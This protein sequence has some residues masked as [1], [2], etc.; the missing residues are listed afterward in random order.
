M[1]TWLMA[2]GRATGYAQ[3]AGTTKYLV[4]AGDLAIPVAGPH[5]SPVYAW[6]PYTWASLSL[7]VIRNFTTAPSTV[8]SWKNGSPGNQA[9]LIGPGQVGL[10]QDLM[11][12]DL[13]AE[14][15]FF[16]WKVV[17]GGGGVL[18][19][20]IIACILS[21]DSPIPMLICGNEI[22]QQSYGHNRFAAIAGMPDAT[23]K[24]DRAKYTFRTPS[25]LS[26]LQVSVYPGNLNGPVI[27]RLRKNSSNG[28]QAIYI[29]QGGFGDFVDRQN[30]DL[31]S[32]GDSVNYKMEIGGTSGKVAFR[33][34]QLRSESQGRQVAAATPSKDGKSLGFGSVAYLPVE[35]VCQWYARQ[36]ADVQTP[37]LCSFLAKNMFVRIGD[38]G[39]NGPSTFR[40]RKNGGDSGLGVIVGPGQKGIF[41]DLENTMDFSPADLLDWQ[42]MAGG[43]WGSIRPTYVGFELSTIGA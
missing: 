3:P 13:L 9:V 22:E 42:I 36:E 26:H 10:F 7:R 19:Y 15:D 23:S 2:A 35:G 18:V 6:G 1:H 21:S 24:E 40:L 5:N 28:N 39:L 17:N 41:E 33:G 4:V 31:I 16:A 43:S 12:N 37:A 14:R 38:N 27:F 29:P 20:T 25:I 8:R 30:T 34:Y 32:P 11:G